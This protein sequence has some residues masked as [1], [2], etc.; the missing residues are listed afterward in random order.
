MDLAMLL[1]L[2][3]DDLDLP[4]WLA[5]ADDDTTLAEL[6]AYYIDYEEDDGE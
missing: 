4:Y 1:A 5:T 3:G 2:Y 6:L